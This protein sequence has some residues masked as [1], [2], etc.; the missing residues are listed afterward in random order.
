MSIIEDDNKTINTNN[1]YYRKSR[2]LEE[3]LE[4]FVILLVLYV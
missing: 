2:K 4:T 3:T 1:M